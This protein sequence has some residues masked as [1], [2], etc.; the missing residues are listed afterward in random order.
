MIEKI[1]LD[2]LLE[3]LKTDVYTEKPTNEPQEYIL[4]EKVGGGETN[5]IKSASIALQ[6][7]A[8]SMYFAASLNERLK[9]AMDQLIELD[10]IG[11][12]KLNSDYNFTDTEN[13]KYR[14]QA[15]YEIKYY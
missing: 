1:I 3:H 8:Q 5:A 6:S 10:E 13:K 2:F 4:I 14:Y 11:K 12:V 7:Y 9:E 15:L